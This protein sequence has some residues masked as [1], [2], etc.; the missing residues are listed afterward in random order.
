MARKE[1]AHKPKQITE[2]IGYPETPMPIKYIVAA[3]AAWAVWV[4]FLVAMAYIRHIEWP[5]YPT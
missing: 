1:P 4:G 3:A 2:V 5:W